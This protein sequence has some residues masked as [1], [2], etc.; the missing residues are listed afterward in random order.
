VLES[1][2]SDSAPGNNLTDFP[3]VRLKSGLQAMAET[4]AAAMSVSAIYRQTGL[5]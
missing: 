4:D 3:L 5:R 1:S 2:S